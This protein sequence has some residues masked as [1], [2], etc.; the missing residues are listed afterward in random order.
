MERYKTFIKHVLGYL[1]CVFGRVKYPKKGKI[2]VGRNVH[3]VNG[4]NIK[5]GHNIEIRPDVDL[6]AGA[7]L[8]IGNG[9]DIGT[10]NRIVGNIIVED[11]VLMGPDNYI[12]SHDHCYEDIF[13]PII[14]QG[15]HAIYNN[16]HE[17]LKI[18]EGS[19]VGTHCA[20]IG[21][22]H[23]GKH[24]VIGANSVVTKDIP[25]YCVAVGTPA[26]IIKRFNVETNKWQRVKC[27]EG[28]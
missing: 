8:K 23:I 11:N 15:V 5:L 2:Y 4:E 12:C 17:E 28:K 24:C 22:V 13:V 20:I 3:F 7:I 26:Q 16:G 18:G 6:F 21:D 14:K 25:D 27:T 10:R 9:C 1:R 19:W